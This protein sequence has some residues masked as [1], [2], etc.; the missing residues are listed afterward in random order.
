MSP[1]PPSPIPPCQRAALP[2]HALQASTSKQPPSVSGLGHQVS[3]GGV[4]GAGGDGEGGWRGRGAGG[5]GGLQ[6]QSGAPL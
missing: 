2:S 4:T 6:L 5:G 3:T 1:I